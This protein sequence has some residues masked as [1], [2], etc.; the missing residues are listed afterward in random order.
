MELTAESALPHN[1]NQRGPNNATIK[2]DARVPPILVFLHVPRSGGTALHNALS[3]HFPPGQICPERMNQLPKI[4][5]REMAGYRLFSGHYR[6]E[7]LELTPQPRLAVTVLRE[8]RQRLVPLYR[9]WRRHAPWMAEGNPGLW[10][11]QTLPLAAFLRSERLEVVEAF[12]NNLARQLAGNCHARGPG[13][14]TRILPD[15]RTALDH[16]DIVPLACRNLLQF[17]AVGFQGSLDAVLAHVSQRMGWPSHAALPLTNA[18]SQPD[19]GLEA[20]PEEEVPPE[21]WPELN[22]LTRLDRM[23]WDFALQRARGAPLLIPGAG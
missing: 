12:D 5:P 13:Y 3:A 15:E 11:A 7:Q 17:D 14:Y 23:V 10:L 20:L 8:P 19:P 6:F 16:M 22:R 4:P 21:A 9:H 18:S 1:G 2:P